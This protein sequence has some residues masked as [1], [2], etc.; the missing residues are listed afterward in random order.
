MRVRRFLVCPAVAVGLLLTPH[1]AGSATAAPPIEVSGTYT[2]IMTG[3]TLPEGPGR[4]QFF[5]FSNAVTLSGSY[6]ATGTAS[7]R[8]VTVGTQVFKCHGEQFITGSLEGVGAGTVTNRSLITCDLTAGVCT[9][10]VV[11]LSGTGA[12]ADVHAVTHSQNGLTEPFG[13]YSGKVVVKGR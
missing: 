9:S 8:C 7:Y 2:S 10:T 4:A 11:S 3:G 5:T 6:T 13:T 12:L 1:L